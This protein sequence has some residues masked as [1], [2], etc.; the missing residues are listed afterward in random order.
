MST[1]FKVGHCV[2]ANIA[3][4]AM[5]VL[6]SSKPKSIPLPQ[7]SG[8]FQFLAHSTHLTNDGNTNILNSN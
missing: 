3:T 1:I 5:A 2:G 4:Q 7:H 6:S 8:S